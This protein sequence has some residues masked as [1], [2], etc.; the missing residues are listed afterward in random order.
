MKQLSLVKEIVSSNNNTGPKNWERLANIGSNENL[1]SC[2]KVD[3]HPSMQLM[4]S[5]VLNQRTEDELELSA[6][7]DIRSIRSTYTFRRI[8]V[9]S[10]PDEEINHQ[11]SICGVSNCHLVPNLSSC[12]SMK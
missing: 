2:P 8:P 3:N 6:S 4:L 1:T 11:K 7:A 5:D 9:I 10:S 12:G